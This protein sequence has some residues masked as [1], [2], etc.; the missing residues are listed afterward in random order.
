MAVGSEPG[1]V[2]ALYQL[3]LGWRKEKAHT[4]DMEGKEKRL[5]SETIDVHCGSILRVCDQGK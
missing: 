4:S 2:V 1:K 5:I 3:R